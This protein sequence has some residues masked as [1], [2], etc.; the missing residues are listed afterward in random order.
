MG[1]R[2]TLSHPV[3]AAIPPGDEGLYKMALGLARQFE[4]LN[5]DEVQNIKKMALV[6]D[7]LFRYP[8]EDE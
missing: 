6:E 5:S 4:P 8:M 3:T 1:L 7:P 2:F